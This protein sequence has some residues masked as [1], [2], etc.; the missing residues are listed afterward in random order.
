MPAK[1]RVQHW[2]QLGEP[3]YVG[4]R[5][6]M[7]QARHQS[8]A[9]STMIHLP[10]HQFNVSSWTVPAHLALTARINCETSAVYPRRVLAALGVRGSQLPFSKPA[11]ASPPPDSHAAFFLTVSHGRHNDTAGTHRHSRL[12]LRHTH[13]AG[14]LSLPRVEASRH[15]IECSTPRPPLRP[16]LDT[17]S[18][19]ALNIA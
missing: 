3:P 13:P 4:Q 1:R 19:V 7:P 2:Q 5:R 12:A 10:P 8:N 15:G 18:S 6:L 14:N 9:Q 11:G 16:V 17:C